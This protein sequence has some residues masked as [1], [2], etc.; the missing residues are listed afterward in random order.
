MKIKTTNVVQP[1]YGDVH[2]SG[3]NNY[4]LRTRMNG[5]HSVKHSDNEGCPI[6]KL[7]YHIVGA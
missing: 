7:D 5:G 3:L 6:K 1:T 2:N 4:L